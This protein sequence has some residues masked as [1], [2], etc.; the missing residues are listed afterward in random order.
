MNKHQIIKHTGYLC[1][2]VFMLFACNSDL[3]EKHKTV[4]L[5]RDSIAAPVLIKAGNFDVISLDSVPP[6]KIIKLSQKPTAVKTPVGFFISMQNFNTPQGLALSSILGGYKDKLG[7][8]WFGTSGNGVSKYDGKS[9]TNYSSAHGLIHNLVECVMEDRQGNIWFGTYGGISKYDGATFENFTTEQ[10]LVDNDIRSM[11]EDSKGNIWSGSILGIDRYNP[12]NKDLFI[13][14][15]KLDDNQEN[16][17]TAIIEDRQGFLWFGNNTGVIK[18]DPSSKAIGKKAFTDISESL[19]IQGELVNDLMED[20]DGIIWVAT[21][22]LVCRYDPSKEGTSSKAFQHFTTAEGLADNT[23]FCITEDNAGNIWFGTKNGVSQFKKTDNSFLNFTKE[24][25]LANNDVRSITEDDFGSLWFGT[26]GGGLSKYMGQSVI[27]FTQKQGLKSDNV[28]AITG[29]NEGNLWFAASNGG[30]HN[31]ELDEQGK[32]VGNFINY[33]ERNGLADQAAMALTTDKKGNLWIGTNDGISKLNGQDLTNYSSEQGLTDNFVN[34]LYTD[35]E[36]NIWVGTFGGGVSKFDGEFFTN[37][38]VEKGLVHKTV[39]GILEDKNGIIWIATRGG[40]SRYDGKSFMNFTRAQGLPDN[41]LSSV[42]QDQSG[43]IIIG[44]WGGG[45]SIIRS[46]EVE[47]LAIPG[48]LSDNES[49]FENFSTAEGLANDV[50][51]SILEDREGNIIIG[52]NVGLTI[53]KGGIG[54]KG[55][56]IAKDAIESYNEKTG[57]PIKDISNNTSMYCDSQEIIWAG[58]GDKLVRF[59][60]RNVKRSAKKPNVVLENIRIN[61]E[62]ISWRSLQGAAKPIDLGAQKTYDTPSHITDELLVFGRKLSLPERDTL[63]N[64]FKNIQF[65]GLRPFYNI[66]ENLV[67]PYSENNIS[68]DFVGI[69][70]TRPHLVRY[71]YKLEGYDKDWSPITDKSTTSFGNISEGDYTFLLKAKSPD[72]IWSEPLIYSFEILPPWYRSWIAKLFY[73]MLILSG[74][75]FINKQQRR[76]FLLKERQRVIKRELE[77][78]KE[79]EKAYTELKLTQAQLIQAEKMASL[80]ELTAGIAHEIQNPLNFVN[81]FS[82]V[83]NELIDEMNE[84]LD[85]GDIDE[86]KLI[87]ADIKQN[88]EKINHHGKRADGIVKG[89]LQ[90]S[91][92]SS[93]IKELIDINVLTDEYLRLAYHGLRAKDKSFNSK[94]ETNFE[95]NIGNIN[96]VSQDIGRVILNL[97]TNAF[98]AVDQKKKQQ[99]EGYDPTVSVSTQKIDKKVVISVR[100][101]GNGISKKVLDKIFQPFF[102]TKPTGQGT[103]LGLSLSYDIIKTHGGEI[104]VET[105]EGIGTTFS[106]LI[107]VG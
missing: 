56:N 63:V 80:G 19:G 95:E 25:G 44:S 13:N 65:D 60:Y 59:D 5:E 73:V 34:V 49:I 87:A 53:L 75:F 76:R 101:N 67:L 66:P 64:R 35:I 15:Y 37:L 97:I 100:D 26:Y 84:E 32:N 94:M 31:Y 83:S 38:T 7:N 43:N 48:N 52:T 78:A 27:E 70:T 82:E 46:N 69:E 91:R 12:A 79:I 81:N 86:A 68:I 14:Y 107:P 40:L 18:Y 98:Y 24:Q 33:K 3:S 23:V 92:K 9:F 103:G 20:K 11:F 51:Y 90:H 21:N 6:P 22:S 61:N 71:Q 54:E 45:V 4:V 72:G 42:I 57:Y 41:K 8:L 39:W 58:T 36:E 96:I 28:F 10:G 85:K 77:N 55:N 50:V 62:P 1:L 30:I 29:D 74:I 93:G 16:S 17:F 2:L 104:K 88:L 102:T 99:V 105:E 89:M 106:I 47:K